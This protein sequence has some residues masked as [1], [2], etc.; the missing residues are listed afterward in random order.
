M[1]VNRFP[2]NSR[3]ADDGAADGG[4]DKGFVIGQLGIIVGG[5]AGL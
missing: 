3:Q 2:Y 5:L 1:P 4:I